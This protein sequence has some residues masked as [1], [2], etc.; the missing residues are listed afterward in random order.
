MQS[1]MRS[2]HRAANYQRSVS[3]VSARGYVRPAVD[4]QIYLC[5]LL[6]CSGSLTSSGLLIG[7]PR[8]LLT[9]YNPQESDMCFL[10]FFASSSA[11]TAAVPYL[12]LC[13]MQ[14]RRTTQPRNWRLRSRVSAFLGMVC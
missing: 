3:G 7:Y 2:R 11:L 14:L 5:R 8:L 13:P 6:G 10:S 12:L 1:L 9:L 4:C